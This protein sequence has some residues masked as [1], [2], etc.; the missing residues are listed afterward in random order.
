MRTAA[1]TLAVVMASAPL[2]AQVMS[3]TDGMPPIEDG[4]LQRS[5]LELKA[6]N[7]GIELKHDERPCVHARATISALTRTVS[8]N[9][10]TRLSG[11]EL[12]AIVNGEGY[13]TIERF[14]SRRS[15]D[16]AGL[17]AALSGRASRKLVIEAN[18]VYD[19]FMAGDT[20]VLMISSSRGYEANAMLF[21][22]VR[23]MF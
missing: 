5:V 3:C 9:F 15:A 20:L 16:L 14:K 4:R 2:G 21:R 1:F 17:D 18:T 6:R 11:Y 12:A 13:F 10:L 8:R 7:P 22:Q 23:E 19:L